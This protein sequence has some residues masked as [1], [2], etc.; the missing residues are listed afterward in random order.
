M[1]T[2]TRADTVVA[3]IVMRASGSGSVH[4]SKLM[5]HAADLDVPLPP[6]V[7]RSLFDAFKVVTSEAERFTYNVPGPNGIVLT[8]RLWSVPFENHKGFKRTYYRDLLADGVI[9]KG[10]QYRQV[11]VGVARFFKDRAAAS[12]LYH[13]VPQ[14]RGLSPFEKDIIT[15]WAEVSQ[16]AVETSQV[17][18]IAKVRTALRENLIN[19]WLRAV[20]APSRDSYFV[21]VDRFED[22]TRLEELVKSTDAFTFDLRFLD[23]RDYHV[24]LVSAALHEHVERS[25]ASARKSL[26]KREMS[27]ARAECKSLLGKLAQFTDL[28]LQAEADEVIALGKQLGMPI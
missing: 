21:H 18:T 3:E 23:P 22:L 20:P 6:L 7:P 1:A 8:A 26:A 25:L 27:K 10:E 17:V 13:F 14:T 24:E 4:V 16:E 12:R 19:D 9:P 2:G 5:D 15:H 11:E 28:D